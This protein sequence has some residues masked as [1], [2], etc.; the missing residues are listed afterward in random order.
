MLAQ[1]DKAVRQ[2]SDCDH[3]LM[4]RLDDDDPA[5]QTEATR[6]SPSIPDEATP[7]AWLPMTMDADGARR[8]H[9]GGIAPS[10]VMARP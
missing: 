1:H 5:S 6:E 10:R 8:S 3:G 9:S 2:G 7:A 4:A